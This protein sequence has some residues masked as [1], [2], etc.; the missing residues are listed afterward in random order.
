VNKWNTPLSLAT[1]H[2][3]ARAR[4]RHLR[5]EADKLDKRADELER[6]YDEL[7][8]PLRRVST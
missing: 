1:L 5:A 7:T 3:K 8:A 4:A 2:D 6:R